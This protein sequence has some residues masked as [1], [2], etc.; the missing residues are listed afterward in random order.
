[1]ATEIGCIVRGL[2][3]YL[4][5]LPGSVESHSH[6]LRDEGLSI[7]ARAP[8]PQ[9]STGGPTFNLVHG[10]R[11]TAHFAQTTLHPM[12]LMPASTDSGPK[13]RHTKS[14]GRWACRTAEPNAGSGLAGKLWAVDFVAPPESIVR[15]FSARRSRRL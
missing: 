10:Q 12:R 8:C 3:A 5:R 1:M 15:H 14:V 6:S 2:S 7:R 11:R 9:V 4:R 13:L